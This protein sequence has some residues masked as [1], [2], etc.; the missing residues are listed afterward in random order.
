MSKAPLRQGRVSANGLEFATLEAGSADAPLALCLHGFPD[1][2]HTWRH[3]LPVLA[4]VGY[5]A[6]APFMRGYA[7][8]AIPADGRYQTALLARDAVALIEALGAK[9][10]A[11]IGHDWGAIAAHGAAIL[12]PE[13]VRK[14]VTMSVP[15][16]TI[17]LAL[18]TS[19]DQQRRSWYIFFFQS[20]FADAAVAANDFA[21]LERI[22]QD[23]SPSWKD[24]KARAEDLD[25]LKRCFREPGVPAAALGYYRAMLD[26]AKQD[27]A[28]AADQVR[29]ATA[30]IP[31]E[32]LYLHG[33][34]DGCIGV[35]TTRGMEAGYPRG[36]RKVIVE[37]AGHFLHLE[38]P[39]VVNDAI[40]EFLGAAMP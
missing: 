40:R 3:L 37:G 29:I 22:W 14:L 27:P 18:A 13:R 32:T 5:H 4:S 28:L 36:L 34:D 6:V 12:A 33:S 35:E 8:T 19:Y 17:G 10:A 30:E 31:V 15:H 7:P 23:W 26:P 20:P 11:V 24:D 21:F 9:R 2:A 1:T 39:R 25:A 38:R 16:R